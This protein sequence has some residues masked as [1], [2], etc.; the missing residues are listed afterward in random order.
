MEKALL[1]KEFEL[2]EV[3][4][5]KQVK[6]NDA[7]L[8][9]TLKELKQRCRGYKGLFYEL[10]KPINPQYD[11][12]VKVSLQKC[13]KFLVVNSAKDAQT[14]SDFLTEKQLQM[15]LL[16]LENLPE[17]VPNPMLPKLPKDTILVYQV[18]EVPRSEPLIDKA[19][20]YFTG[21]KVFCKS[22]AEAKRLQKELQLKDIVTED[23]TQFRHGMISGGN[24]P[25]IFKLQLGT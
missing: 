11:I 25:N 16:V 23:G 22:F 3:E 1:E 2:S 21:A 18:I 8:I 12:A 6:S 9:Q 24:Q 10:V 5:E 20:K 4:A 14:V 15:E 13:L 19:V 7:K 17:Q